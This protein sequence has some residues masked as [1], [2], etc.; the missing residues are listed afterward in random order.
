MVFF[1]L[2]L[3]PYLDEIYSYLTKQKL[4]V[5]SGSSNSS[6]FVGQTIH[7]RV[8]RNKFPAH[9]GTMIPSTEGREGNLRFYKKGEYSET[10][11]LYRQ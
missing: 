5:S 1:L 7:A 2:P 6:T 3:K 8:E 10:G 9:F 4:W 11:L